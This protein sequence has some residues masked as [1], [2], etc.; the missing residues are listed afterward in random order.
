M[1]L[2]LACDLQSTPF[3]SLSVAEPEQ[4]SWYFALATNP[5]FK[6]VSA[7]PRFSNCLLFW[8]RTDQVCYL[9]AGETIRVSKQTLAGVLL[10]PLRGPLSEWKLE[11]SFVQF[12]LSCLFNKQCNPSHLS[13]VFTSPFWGCDSQ[14]FLQ[15]P[16][17][18]QQ[19][20]QSSPEVFFGGFWGM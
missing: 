14:V 10:L 7:Q 5:P 11:S 12:T 19:N 2:A 3:P 4:V 15:L 6:I 20:Y 1:S 17:L 8:S 16:E 13:W 9:L 18:I